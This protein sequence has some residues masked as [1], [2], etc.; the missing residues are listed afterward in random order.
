MKLIKF[1]VLDSTNDY[2]K[3]NFKDFESYDIVAAENQ[4]LGRGRR[5]NTWV[6]SKGM[7]LFSFFLKDQ[8]LS[9]SD[10]TKIPLVVGIATLKALKKIE[11][12]DYKLK[13][14]NDIFLKNKKLCGILV[15]KVENNFVVGIGINV[16]NKVP[17]E[18]EN[19][20]ISFGKD[21]DLDKIMLTIV[22]EFSM[23]YEKFLLGDWEN[24]VKEI[25]SYNFLKNKEIRVKILDKFYEGIAKDI[26]K[27][28]RLEVEIGSGENK[29]TQFFS[30][31]EI[32]IEI[33]HKK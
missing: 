18:V 26:T 13:W 24:I 29:E 21:Y 33:E 1:E 16:R 22:E 30:A 25:N 27:D 17:K 4:T 7:A 15:E 31:G 2:M 3:R 23:Y 11:E 28:G 20:A 14:I 8:K 12:N 32:E 5:G 9:I 19:I 10:Y 6:S